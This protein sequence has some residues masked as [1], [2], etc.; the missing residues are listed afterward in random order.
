MT[1]TEAKPEAADGI[2][3][4][5][6]LQT[7]FKKGFL[8]LSQ[9]WQG[10][11]QPASM[12]LRLGHRAWRIQASFL[13]GMNQTVQDKIE[14]FSMY[15]LDLTDGAVLETG[16]VYIVELQESLALPP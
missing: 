12:D 2:L 13:P 3:P 7:C 15:E 11:I 16:C 14:K 1:L 10:Q 8:S 5:Q 9:N 4:V 6:E